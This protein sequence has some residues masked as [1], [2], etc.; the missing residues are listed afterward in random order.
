MS[1]TTNIATENFKRKLAELHQAREDARLA[2]EQAERERI[3]RANKF[4]PEALA[5]V[6]AI[7]EIEEL[8]G[9][10]LYFY[11]KDVENC[12]VFYNKEQEHFHFTLNVPTGASLN[13]QHAFIHCTGGYMKKRYV[14]GGEYFDTLDELLAAIGAYCAE[15]VLP[16]AAKAT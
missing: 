9:A 7:D 2:S 12:R 4:K 8:S 15:L 3:E 6:A 5:V 11:D 1:E 10:R 13:C 14:L 16:T